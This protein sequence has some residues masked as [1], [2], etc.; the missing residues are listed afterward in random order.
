M[1][2]SKRIIPPLNG[3]RTHPLSEHALDVL[4][5][6]K[7]APMPCARINPGVMNRLHREY[8]IVDVMLKSPF[9]TTP[10]KTMHCKITKAGIAR[11]DLED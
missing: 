2:N 10:D 7:T 4:T 1:V 9:K 5:R 3:T 11:L 6:L 8:F